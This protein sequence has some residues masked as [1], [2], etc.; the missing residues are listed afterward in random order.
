MTITAVST[1]TV[2]LAGAPNTGKSTVF[3]A[4][5]G[6][7]QHTGNWPGKTVER[8]TGVHRRN[9]TAF[10]LVDLPGSY[11][12]SA[13]SVEEEAAR[14]F[15]ATERPDVVVAVVDA[16]SL[17][18]NLYLVRELLELG[19]PTVI[20]L[21]MMDV[22]RAAGL[23]VEVEALQTALGVPVVPLVA[24][25]G[26]GIDEL[27]DAIEQAAQAGVTRD[28]ASLPLEP[29]TA[30]LLDTLD[31]AVPLSIDLPYPRDWLLTK[32]LEGDAALAKAVKAEAPP[33]A[34]LEI[35]ATLRHRDGAAIEIA[36][37][38]YDWAAGV[39][40]Q[41]VRRE[42]NEPSWA[43][44]ADHVLMH[45]LGGVL[46]FVAVIFGVYWLMFSVAVPMQRFL[47]NK[48]VGGS[49]TR[50]ESALAGWPH[51]SVSL[52]SDGV[53][54]G[55]GTVLT[56]IP[57]LALLFFALTVL[58]DIGYMARAAFVMD[59]FMNL[60]GLRGKSFLPLF[61]GWGC[62]VPAISGSRIVES[63]SARLTTILVAPLVP[64][65]ARMVVIALLATAFFG[66]AAAFVAWGMVMVNLAVLAVVALLISRLLFRGHESSFVME[67]P[68]YHVPNLRSVLLTTLT[69]L[70]HFV[71]FTGTVILAVSL[72]VWA[73]ATFPGSGI[74]QSFLGH[75]GRGL[76]PLGG[77]MGLDWRAMVALLT[78]FVAKEQTIATFGILLGSNGDAAL[79]TSLAGIMTPAAA[80]AFIALQMLFIPCAASTVTLFRETRSW[81]W[82]GFA[83]GYMLIVSFGVAILIYQ[84]ARLLGLGV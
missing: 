26:K 33:E 67:L 21:N 71:T 62:N 16:S 64:C 27:L 77:L 14:D 83:V 58:E 76:A 19:L 70:R 79:R 60:I 17:E 11:S 46:A 30:R 78:S 49:A 45:P 25:Q 4:L 57:I 39:Y 42:R 63:P 80:L 81:R 72:V 8:K 6:L 24:R 37:A 59:R 44:R 3:N 7:R 34:R 84:T 53:I 36:G 74:D 55:V 61:V 35:E 48:L 10:S 1:L 68:R 28:I 31:E 5:T 73:L 47:D 82:T 56:F 41:T 65:S 50:V 32:L 43:K 9:G 29:D 40:H 52:L 20:A 15:L 51:W 22:A 66:S 18:R 13:N 54:G 75:I 69:R 23:E 2:A 12:L 38:R